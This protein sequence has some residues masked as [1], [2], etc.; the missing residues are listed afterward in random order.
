MT[1]RSAALHLTFTFNLAVYVEFSLLPGI[2]YAVPA[3]ILSGIPAGFCLASYLASLPAFSLEFYN[4]IFLP[5][6]YVAFNLTFIACIISGI[7]API[8]SGMVAGIKSGSLSDIPVGIKSRNL[9]DMSAGTQRL[10]V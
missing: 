5:A 2:L 9:S 4:L 6:F 3:R 7:F 8:L 10:P 1:I